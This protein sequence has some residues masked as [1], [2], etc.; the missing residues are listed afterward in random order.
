MVPKMHKREIEVESVSECLK[1]LKRLMQSMVKLKRSGFGV[2]RSSS[3][4]TIHSNN[5]IVYLDS[6]AQGS[7]N[8]FNCPRVTLHIPNS[9]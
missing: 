4:R 8:I 7:G 1:T 9:F 6:V 5:Q 2:T 3:K